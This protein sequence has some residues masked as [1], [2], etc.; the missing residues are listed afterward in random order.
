MSKKALFPVMIGMVAIIV[1]LILHF[2]KE[3][4]EKWDISEFTESEFTNTIGMELVRIEPSSFQMGQ[5][6]SPQKVA[7]SPPVVVRDWATSPLEPPIIIP[8]SDPCYPGL[9]SRQRQGIPSL[10]VMPGGRIW[11][12]WYAGPSGGE[13]ENNYVVLASSGDDG[14]TWEEVL[15]VDPDG[16]GPL[17]AFDP[18]IWVDPSGRLWFFFATADDGEVEAHDGT[19]V[20]LSGKDNA[21][22]WVMIAS[23]GRK[24][25]TAWGAPRHIA[26]GVMMCKPTVLRNGEWLFPISDWEVR[27][28]KDPEAASAGVYVSQ[29]GGESFSLRGAALVPVEA[30]NFDEHMIVERN[31]GSLWMLVR[32]HPQ[33]SD[34]I[35]ESVSWDGGATWSEVKPSAIKHLH[36]RFFITRLQSGSLLLVKHGRIDERLRRPPHERRDLR[37]FVSD[38]DG[39]TWIGGLMLDEREQVS[40][41]DGQQAEDGRIYVTYDHMRR[42]D[43]AIHMVVFTEEDVRAGEIVSES[44]RLQVVISKPGRQW[45]DLPGDQLAQPSYAQ[46]ISNSLGMTLVSIPKG[47]F[48]MGEERH[49]EWQSLGLDF[50]EA[51]VR[52]VTIS[53]GFLMSRTEVTNAQYERFRPGHRKDMA[54]YYEFIK[55]NSGGDF[56]DGDDDP[57]IGVSWHDAVAFCE[58][59]SEQEDKPY[60]LPTEAEWE[61][62]CR[63]GTTTKYHTGD[64][65]SP[66]LLKEQNPIKGGAGPHRRLQTVDTRVG[67]TPANAWGLHDMHG[68]VEEWVL[69]WYAS[70][71]DLAE[72][73]PVG[74]DDGWYKVNR[75]GSHNTPAYYLRSANRS[76]ALPDDKHW[77][78]G[79]RVVQAP[80]PK[81]QTWSN[82][83]IPQHQR[84]VSQKAKAWSVAGSEPLFADPVPYQVPPLDE[85][86]PWYKH[87]HTP[88]LT[89]CEN[90]DIL[91]FWFNCR[92]ELGREHAILGTRLRDGAD[93]FTPADIAAN[94]PDRNNHGYALVKLDDELLFFQ[95]NH[96][97]GY[98]SNA[99]LA[100]SR[101]LDNGATWTS[102][103]IILGDHIVGIYAVANHHPV[104]ANG[105]ILLATD[106]TGGGGLLRG[107]DRATRWEIMTATSKGVGVAPPGTPRTEMI[108][109][110][111]ALAECA[112]GSLLAFTRDDGRV[113]NGR[114]PWNRSTDGGRTWQ[115]GPSELPSISTTQKPLMLR[116]KEGPLLLLSFTDD[117][118]GTSKRPITGILIKDAE[119][120]E[121]RIFG[122][123][124]ALS[125]DNGVTW[126]TI[127]PLSAGC[128]PKPMTSVR[129]GA[130]TMDATHGIIG[131]Y[132]SGSQSPD[133]IIHVADSR[134]YYRF[135][136]GWLE[137]PL[138]AATVEE[139][140]REEEI[141]KR[142]HEFGSLGTAI[143]GRY[144]E[145]D[146][147]AK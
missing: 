136:L 85:A 28:N 120:S 138:P 67:R 92:Q 42:R 16:P 102:P 121:R 46:E 89:W 124:A 49:P 7:V 17:R 39:L 48:L 80:M 1:V 125:Y 135:N 54:V 128:P 9:E 99:N 117:Y 86:I 142:I 68:N 70:Y 123:F 87:H 118:V 71:R 113:Y 40:Y 4:G 74:P 66:D 109:Y 26:P 15:V 137:Q 10:A 6:R 36:S 75:G 127:R 37:A 53:T 83:Y 100:L 129:D 146:F 35:G 134:Y 94:A 52:D 76:G 32:T 95:G 143:P 27:V 30:R 60:R 18:E 19:T 44:G 116:L 133:G 21:Q 139:K 11:A 132:F 63:A 25:D 105:D 97:G 88:A 110:H 51:P 22:T 14:E 34:S 82:N 130:W 31:D 101:S 72:T 93:S 81:T 131:G 144:G 96:V 78:I 108:G 114:M 103:S 107:S 3:P 104:T 12:T 122:A 106:A 41:P 140:N 112:D 141:E 58:W 2:L 20:K 50:D 45:I 8:A 5:S 69:D 126:P 98:S 29:D 145:F 56:G 33:F 61:Y 57:V 38:D 84:E 91:I 147:E 115:S 77:F 23:D 13:D 59:L 64:E 90:G 47:S 65:L 73:D 111:P 62:V 79:F 119:G 24:A 55:N 43:K